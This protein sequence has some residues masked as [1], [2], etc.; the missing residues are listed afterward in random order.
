M[1]K[2]KR[3]HNNIQSTV[4]RV[5]NSNGFRDFFSINMYYTLNVQLP[6]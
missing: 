4:D 2:R 1:T 3:N 6:I 5:G